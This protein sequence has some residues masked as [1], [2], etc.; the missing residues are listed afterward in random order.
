MSVNLTSNRERQGIHKLSTF[1]FPVR[2]FQARGKINKITLFAFNFVLEKS[3][4]F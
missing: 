1:A 4:Y 3:H 2:T